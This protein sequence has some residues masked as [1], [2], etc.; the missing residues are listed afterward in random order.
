MHASI[1]HASL[2]E[3]VRRRRNRCSFTRSTVSRLLCPC[4]RACVR[5]RVYVEVGVRGNEEKGVKGGTITVPRFRATTRR[6]PFD[7]IPDAV[8]QTNRR[9]TPPTLRPSATPPPPPSAS[10]SQR[11]PRTAFYISFSFLPS[12]CRGGNPRSRRER[13]RYGGESI[14]LLHREGGSG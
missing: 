5:K 1:S 4:M 14:V 11:S 8:F 13:R 10:R 12:T 7:L 9:Y 3:R 6:H 2:G